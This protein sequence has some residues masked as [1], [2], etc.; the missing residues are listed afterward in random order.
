MNG[1]RIRDWLLVLV[2]IGLIAWGLYDR[3]PGGPEVFVG[4]FCLVYGLWSRNGPTDSS[5]SEG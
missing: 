4:V 3:I 1:S 5:T 2:G